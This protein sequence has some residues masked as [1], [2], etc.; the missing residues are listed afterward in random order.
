MQAIV[1][2][3]N[4][5]TFPIGAAVEVM[6]CDIDILSLEVGSVEIILEDGYKILAEFSN[7]VYAPNVS[8]VVEA[9][10]NGEGGFVAG[11]SDARLPE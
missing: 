1:W 2:F 7:I 6:A 4:A 5:L 9:F 3:K 8:F 10:K 11:F